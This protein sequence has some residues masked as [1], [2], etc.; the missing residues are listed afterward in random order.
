[1]K[2][3]ASLM[4]CIKKYSQL[5]FVKSKVR[6]I[7][8]ILLSLTM[9]GVFLYFKPNGLKHL[10]LGC[11]FATLSGILVNCKKL[12]VW[13]A[14]IALGVY[15][16]IVPYK[17]FQRMEF[18]ITDVTLLYRK[19]TLLCVAM[20]YVIYLFFFLFTQRIPLAI[21]LGNVFLMVV[22]VAEF[23]V[24]SFRGQAISFE[25]LRVIN[26]AA[27]V[28][29]NYDYTPSSELIYSL[30]WFIFF[31]VCILKLAVH[32]KSIQSKYPKYRAV[33][34]HVIAS[35]ASAVCVFSFFFILLG[36]SFLKDHGIDDS[37][38][39]YYRTDTLHGC[40]L[41]PFVEYSC[42]KIEVPK[43]YSAETVLQIGKAAEEKFVPLKEECD[44]RPNVIVIM[45]EAFG[46]PR[47]L[48]D[49][50]TKEPIM[51]F[52]DSL[53]SAENAI[54]GK[55]YMSIL[56][57]L[58]VNSEFE[59]LT[60][61]SMRFLPYTMIPYSS[62][63]DREMPSLVSEFE[64]LG[65][66]SM[67]IHPNV[68]NA[69][70]RDRVYQYF[71]FDQF[72]D[73][74]SF[75]T[76]V[77][78]V[79]NYVSDRSNYQELIYRYENRDASKPFFA[80]DVTIQN[81]SPYW[82]KNRPQRILSVGGV[83]SQVKDEYCMEESY[84]SLLKQSDE[85]LQE[86]LAYFETVEEP[87]VVCFF[88][89]HQAL[90]SDEFYSAIYEGR[91]LSEESKTQLMYSVP[92]VI[93]ANY[94]ADFFHPGDVSANYLGGVLLEELGLPMSQF[95]MF[96]SELRR[97]YPILSARQLSDAGGIKHDNL[98]KDDLPAISE[99]WTFAYDGMFASKVTEETF[100]PKSYRD[101]S[102][103][104]TSGVQKGAK[105]YEEY[106]SVTHALGMT[107]EGDVVTNSLEA[108]LYNYQLGQRVFEADVQIAS[109]GVMVLRHDWE[110]S[111]GQDVAFGWTDD[112][113]PV[114]ASK[115][116][117]AAPIY[118]K[119]TP[120]TLE[121]WFGIMEEY[122]DVWFVTDTKYSPTVSKDMQIFVDTAKNSHRE[123]VLD[124]VI[125]QLYYQEM[126]DEV[127][128]VY[129]FENYLLTIYYTGYPE[130]S[131]SMLKFMEEKG[132]GVLTMPADTWAGTARIREELKDKKFKVYLHTVDDPEAAMRYLKEV[133]G[134][135][136]DC[137]TEPQMDYLTSHGDAS[138]DT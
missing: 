135:Y 88:G 11:G 101:K 110:S 41:Y 131:A 114:P 78:Y 47:V 129:P 72:V 65:Y 105:W 63:V 32:W 28:M 31:T 97:E 45:N 138:G 133:G 60:G 54:R 59:V 8:G 19:S 6:L 18:P 61:N 89:D 4:K 23:Y 33:L 91:E 107:G 126:Y 15:L 80:F 36:T 84:L 100:T 99:Y 49:F 116:F 93:W 5:I 67:A 57:G 90:L 17:L 70:D 120:L 106:S 50:E 55:L 35:I 103:E 30:L 95:R 10:V 34:V 66:S 14:W 20:I 64:A 113:R 25:D 16:I 94:D 132:I 39:L 128:A 124:R 43:D 12:P 37:L 82:D 21:A 27:M 58:T 81:H 92:Y 79:G 51:P 71:G 76:E 22:T 127:N 119:Y 86:L 48:G 137:I 69:Y 26:T 9:I 77:E 13:P 24:I 46:D 40:L 112:A 118:G 1:M 2:E 53:Y 73:L 109:D 121:D 62:G 29:G 123:S 3:N 115:E 83:E 117:K 7:F 102:P 87:T 134:L 125:V 52:L 44:Q 136:S 98:K 96:Q 75:K 38:W 104:K 111:L 85:A 56:G 68:K 130:D 42:N 108:F 122:S 74:L